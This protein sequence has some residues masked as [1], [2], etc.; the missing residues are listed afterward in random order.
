[1]WLFFFLCVLITFLE[2]LE[3]IKNVIE[4]KNFTVERQRKEITSAQVEKSSTRQALLNSMIKHAN[5][6]FDGETKKQ[7]YDLQSAIDISNG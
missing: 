7:F 1:M 5:K 4:T 2:K 3:T 6:F